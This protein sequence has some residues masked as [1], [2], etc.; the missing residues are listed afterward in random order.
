M[1]YWTR[2][3]VLVTGG[4]GFIGSYL[5]EALV[6]AGAHVTVA[7]DGSTGKM[8]NLAAVQDDVAIRRMDLRRWH[9]CLTVTEGQEVVMHLAGYARGVG[10]HSKHHGELL[11]NNAVLN[12]NM[13]EA[14]RQSGVE[15]YLVTSSSLVYDDSA[16]SPLREGDPLKPA[17]AHLGYGGAKLLAEQQAQHYAREYG[18][19]IAIVRPFTV[20]GGLYERQ[21][22]KP[23]VVP[24]LLAKVMQDEG[25]IVVWGTGQQRRNFINVRDVAHCMML[26]TERHANACPVNLG[27]EQT[28]T[29]ADLVQMLWELAG[30]TPRMIVFDRTKPEGRFCRSADSTLLRSIIGD[31]QLMT[32]LRQGL[33]ELVQGYEEAHR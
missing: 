30:G 8:A 27:F 5:V 13:L 12:L 14:A 17:G 16:S 20:Y 26:V 6:E 24:E 18:M 15:R 29:I 22:D 2:R 32:D 31:Y 11:Y 10:Y 25:P 28:I 7:D 19:K 9:N 23:Q 3:R 21:K 4:A 33:E 1:G